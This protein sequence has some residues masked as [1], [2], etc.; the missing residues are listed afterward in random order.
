MSLIS[1]EDQHTLRTL[2]EGLESDVTITN[3]TQR[4][5]LLIVPGQE[6]DYCKETRELLEEVTALSEK[7]H[8]DTRDFVSDKQEADGLGVTRIPAFVL[9][10][11]ARGKVRYF[12]IPAGYE[13]ST[14][15]E[16]LI[17]V[18]RGTTNLS[19]TT[20]QIL[21]TVEQDLHIQ[22][23]VTPT[24]PYCPRAARLAHKLAIENEH[25]TADVV[26]VSE[27]I[28]MAQLYGVQGVPKTVVNERIEMV[29]AL[30]EPRFMQQ[31]FAALDK[32][33]ATS[34]SSPGEA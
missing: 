6:C 17:D 25:I 19:D 15:I 2:F 10:G 22:V 5:S 33:E 16:D 18:S 24:C 14:L 30:P 3:F 32:E 20:R 28:D 8:L 31:L 21:A 12:G 1:L 29:G 23:F 26:E 13:F 7:L 34:R 27:F 11:R 9:Q 4:D